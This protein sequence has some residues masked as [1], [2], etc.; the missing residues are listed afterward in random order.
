MD[1]DAELARVVIEVIENAS[2][3]ARSKSDINDECTTRKPVTREL[4]DSDVHDLITFFE[5]LDN[6]DREMQD[7]G[8]SS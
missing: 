6:W 5:T 8:E 4:S 2:V 3:Q 1:D 7:R